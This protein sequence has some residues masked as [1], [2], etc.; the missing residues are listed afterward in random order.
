[1]DKQY[2]IDWDFDVVYHDGK[3]FVSIQYDK[4]NAK[5]FKKLSQEKIHE[6]VKAIV[7]QI[8]KAM[9]KDMEIDGVIIMDDAQDPSYT[10][11]Y[12]DGR[13]DIK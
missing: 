11:T 4:D 7:D 2:K 10:F 13:L 6:F 8:N 5:A 9:K 3:V 1:M 12:K